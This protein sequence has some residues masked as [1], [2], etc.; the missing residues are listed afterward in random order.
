[1]ADGG[2]TMSVSGPTGR[3]GRASGKGIKSRWAAGKEI[4]PGTSLITYFSFLFSFLKH[5]TPNSNPYF[6]I[7]ISKSD[8]N[9]SFEFKFSKRQK[10]Y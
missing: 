1:V 10:Q 2:E 3:V 8:S 7:H 6:E 4:G 5:L 9:F